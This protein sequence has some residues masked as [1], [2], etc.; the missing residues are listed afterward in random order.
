MN[1]N[2]LITF[3]ASPSQTILEIDNHANSPEH[4]ENIQITVIMAYS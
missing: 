2:K 3:S 1:M 4:G